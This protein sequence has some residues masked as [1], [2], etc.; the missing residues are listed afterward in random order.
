M[1]GIADP[2]DDDITEESERGELSR[3]GW[4]DA[5]VRRNPTTPSDHGSAPDQDPA[6]GRARDPELENPDAGPGTEE[7]STG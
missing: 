3:A 5:D 7:A 4:A 1:S 6:K 2:R